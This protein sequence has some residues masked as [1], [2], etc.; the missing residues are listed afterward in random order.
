[1]LA[2]AFLV[3]IGMALVADGFGFHI[4]RGYIY[5]AMAFAALVEVFN[6]LAQRNRRV[7]RRHDSPGH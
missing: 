6:V 1:M 7:R 4:P 2:L 3:L 5:S